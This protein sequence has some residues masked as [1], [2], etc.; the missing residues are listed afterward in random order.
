MIPPKEK[1]LKYFHLLVACCLYV[2]FFMT[3]FILG[4]YDFLQGKESEKNFIYHSNI[5]VFIILVQGLDIFLNFF[6][7]QIQDVKEIKEPGD[8]AIRYIKGSFITDCIAVVPYSVINPKFIVLR[9]LKLLKFG[10]YQKYFDEFIIETFQ[11]SVEKEQ[12][13]KMIDII[14]LLV[15]LF[16]VSHFFACSWILIGKQALENDNGW[17]Y[18][19]SAAGIQRPDY[20]SLYISAVYWVI[21]SFSSVGYG[22]IKGHTKEE[23]QFQIVVE[24]IGIGFYGYMIGTFQQIFASIQS[25]DQLADQ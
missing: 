21:T 5:Y 3:G 20:W 15:V 16:F 19:N 2:D 6:K 10:I 12:L 14:D 1:K 13:A 11:T 8:V 17:I 7:I 4:N 23:Y 24:M 18:Q 9:Y 22:D 25:K